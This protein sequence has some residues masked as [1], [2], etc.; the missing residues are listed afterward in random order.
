ML[1]ITVFTV[2]SLFFAENH[3][4]CHFFTSLWVW[5]G[6]W[7]LNCQIFTKKWSKTTPLMTPQLTPLLHPLKTSKMSEI[8]E[9]S[10]L[11]NSLS[12]IRRFWH[13]SQFWQFCTFMTRLWTTLLTRLWTTLLTRLWTPHSDT[14]WH[15][16]QKPALNTA[17]LRKCPKTEKFPKIWEWS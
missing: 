15:F 1:K 11:Q 13:F 5:I 14:V 7:K 16:S 9:M 12:P 2:F 6:F 17:K 8:S 3:G 10:V 4:F